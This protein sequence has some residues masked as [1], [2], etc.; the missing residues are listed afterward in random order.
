MLAANESSQSWPTNT[1]KC[2][3]IDIKWQKGTRSY[4]TDERVWQWCHWLW[5]KWLKWCRSC[6]D[7]DSDEGG[8]GG[9][10]SK[11]LQLQEGTMWKKLARWGWVMQFLNGTRKASD[12]KL[13]VATAFVDFRK[14]FNCVSHSFLLPSSPELKHKFVI[15]GN[16]LS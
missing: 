8:G 14:A 4:Q 5:G 3:D 13:V 2:R 16:L 9:G 11:K 15:E 1:E 12:Y 6:I 7:R 10:S